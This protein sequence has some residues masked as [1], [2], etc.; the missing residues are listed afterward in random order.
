MNDAQPKH[1]VDVLLQLYPKISREAAARLRAICDEVLLVPPQFIIDDD[2][3]LP[4]LQGR[5]A[6]PQHT[7]RYPFEKLVRPLQS[8]LVRNGKSSTVSAAA[9]NYERRFPQVRLSTRDF[10]EDPKYK[11][12]GVRVFRV[13]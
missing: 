10:D 11:V 3:P 12:P 1:P 4:N 2:V 8:F 7:V 6:K 5:A 9:A 13:Y